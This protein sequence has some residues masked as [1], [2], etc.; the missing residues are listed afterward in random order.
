MGLKRGGQAPSEF[1]KRM[2]PSELGY[3]A[4]LYRID[5]WGEQRADLRA[6]IVASTMANIN[7]DPKKTPPFKATQF[8][9][10]HYVDPVKQN[11]VLRDNL[12]AAFNVKLDPRRVRKGK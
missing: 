1:L 2:R 12:L 3:F 10:Y 9:P 11:A 6:G 5:P 8:M 7:R 4:A